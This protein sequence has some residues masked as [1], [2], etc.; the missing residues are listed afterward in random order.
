MIIGR[1]SQG[2]WPC[3]LSCSLVVLLCLL[4]FLSPDLVTFLCFHCE[5]IL[6][7]ILD[8]SIA[9]IH[10]EEAICAEHLFTEELTVPLEI[11]P[12]PF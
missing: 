5:S 10:M 7:A 11:D 4:V 3:L 1:G 9:D 2:T 12:D 6:V 8:G